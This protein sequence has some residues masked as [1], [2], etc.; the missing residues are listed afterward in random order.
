MRIETE[1][2]IIREIE[3]S[4][5]SAIISMSADGSLN[6]V[7]FDTNCASW[8]DN[9]IVEARALTAKD[10]PLVSFLAYTI[11][12]KG[13]DLV[14]GSVGCS[15]YED[16]KKVGITYCIGAPYRNHG[17]ATEAAKAYTQYFFQRYTVN[18]MIATIR[19]ANEFSWKV[20]EKSGYRLTERRMYQDIN[21][22]SEEFYRFYAMTLSGIS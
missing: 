14:I 10:D 6:D 22:T 12:L 8:I 21:D 7:G 15:Y 3:P 13:T 17:Y 5:A 9:W 20:I 19:E 11:Q 16:L 2:L 1:R 18:E 4:D